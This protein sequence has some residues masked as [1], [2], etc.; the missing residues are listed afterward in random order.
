MGVARI[1]N[2]CFASNDRL[3]LDANVWLFLYCPHGNPNAHQPRVYS[4]AFKSI[5]SAG[6]KIYLCSIVL[7]EFIYR[8][9]RLAHEL[10]L[11]R[12]AAPEDFKRFRK[13]SKFKPVAK[14]VSDAVNRFSKH[15]SRI[16]E[17]F[18][19]PDVMRAL[20]EFESGRHDWNDLL[21]ADLCVKNQLSLVT[22]DED[23]SARTIPILTANAMLI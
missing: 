2:Y 13:S 22:D 9:C 14:A 5:L 11:A 19:S 18:Q 7:S 17:D 12:N 6:S 10:L 3:L 1:E 23:F 4:E 16:N 15:A 8:Y 21:I 20:T